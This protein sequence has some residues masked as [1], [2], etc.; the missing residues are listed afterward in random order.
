M[1]GRANRRR[2]HQAERAVCQY[3]RTHGWPDAMTTRAKLGHDGATA[4]GDISGVPACI[5][6]KDV[7]GSSWPTWIAQA[8][9]EARPGQQWIVVRRKRGTP[10]VGKWDAATGHNGEGPAFRHDFSE[11]IGHLS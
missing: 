4:P 11:A 1:N 9:A 6:V 8:R 7:A 2:G 10:D 5:E 3:L